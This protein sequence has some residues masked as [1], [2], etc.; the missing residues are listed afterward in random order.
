MKGIGSD[1]W[2]FFTSITLGIVL[3]AL[4][5]ILSFIETLIPQSA[6]TRE[7]DY[8]SQYGV[9]GYRWIKA[10]GLDNIYGSWYFLLLTVLFFLNLSFNTY[11]RL[12]A[13]IRWWHTDF[14]RTD[15]SKLAA[16]PLHRRL[17]L[18][19]ASTN[20]KLIKEKVRSVLR[21][22]FYRV[23]E[24]PQG[25]FAEKWKFERFG[26]DVLHLSLLAVI[27]GLILTFA[28]GFRTIQIAH[29]GEV[30]EVSN[31]G[32]KV[33]V[34]DF[35]SENYPDSE[36]VMDWKSTLTI[37]EDGQPVKTQTIEVNK[38][39]IYKGIWFY[40]TAF[41][42]DWQGAAQVTLRVMRTS[43]GKDLGEF[44]AKVD[45]GFTI[46]DEGVF[47]AVKTFLPDFDLTEN[48][49]AYSR[50]QRLLNP[51][52][53]IE[54]FD[55]KGN[56]LMR[57]WSFSQLGMQALAEQYL[58]DLPYRIRLV[59]MKAPEFTGLQITYDPGMPVAYGGFVMMFVGFLIHLF[60][61]H[62]VIW[63]RLEQEAIVIGGMARKNPKGFAQEFERI[64]RAL[65]VRLNARTRTETETETERETQELE[66]INV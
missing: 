58:K 14:A 63:V 44:T 25:L 16:L 8:I 55:T 54:V 41:G 24:T 56:R 19:P 21:R 26:I 32:F 5:L 60:F 35:W 66:T 1:L 38:P 51:A 36:R 6:W 29:K 22:R 4:I 46:P 45:D 47:V 53:Y 17:E 42:Q 31:G 64:V 43:D 50:T 57:T 9:E 65:Q 2:N 27:I 18:G 3:L 48:G 62:K 37:L 28:L 52:A 20:P 11:V 39:L 7:V 30:F 59:G 49:I 33:K 10:L 13:S 40:Q 61:K 34:E 15:T 12:R 23:K